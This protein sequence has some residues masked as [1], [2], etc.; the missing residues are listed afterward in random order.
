MPICVATVWRVA[1]IPSYLGYVKSTDRVS[2]SEASVPL[3]FGFEE[4]EIPTPSYYGC[5][6]AAD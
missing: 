6:K 1:E 3:D 2:F 5:R 4:F